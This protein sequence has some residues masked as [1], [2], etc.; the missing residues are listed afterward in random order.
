MLHVIERQGR[1]VDLY[2]IIESTD[3]T[4]C[5]NKPVIADS[6]SRPHMVMHIFQGT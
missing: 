4:E 6:S 5:C 3:A 2:Q 1:L